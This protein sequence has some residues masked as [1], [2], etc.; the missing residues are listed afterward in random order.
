MTKLSILICTM[1]GREEFLSRIIG[2]LKKQTEGKSVEIITDGESGSIGEKRNRLLNKA[3][4]T[5]CVFVDDDDLVSQR[6]VEF[7]M[8]AIE[9]RYDCC[10]LRGMY[11]QDGSFLKPFI[12]SNVYS[13]Y[14]EDKNAYYRYPNHLNPM[15]T[16]IAR[17]IGFPA[18]NFGEDTDF[19]TRLKRSGL[20]KTEYPCGEILYFYYFR[21]RK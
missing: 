3:S 19:A 13:H 14:H 11:Y 9:G 12:H 20:I 1:P 4:G 17:Q 6:Y 16:D 10:E 7:I 15:K 21:T 18:T 5:Y 8:P 2:I